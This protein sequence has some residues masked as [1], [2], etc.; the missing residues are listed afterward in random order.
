MSRVWF[1]LPDV[2]RATLKMVSWWL[3]GFAVLCDWIGSNMDFF[4]ACDTSMPLETY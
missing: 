2:D 3:G 1:S 4:T